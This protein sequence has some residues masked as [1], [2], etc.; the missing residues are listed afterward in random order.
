LDHKKNVPFQRD[1]LVKIFEVLGT[2][3][4]RDWPG[5]TQYP[6]YQNMQ[7][8][9]HYQPKLTEWCN[10]RFRNKEATDLLRQLF[11]YNPETR[12]TAKSAFHHKWFSEDPK[13]T[14]NAFYNLQSNQCPPLRRITQDEASLA[15]TSN[16][17]ANSKPASGQQQ[18]MMTSGSRKKQRLD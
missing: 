5:L 3:S 13:P 17:F 14:R 10:T 9:E 16:A 8:L 7:G 2:P 4:T 12:L 15:H 6:E 18:Y 1:Q 11:T